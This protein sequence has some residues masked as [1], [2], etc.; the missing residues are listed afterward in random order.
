[1]PDN[2]IDI[3]NPVVVNRSIWSINDRLATYNRRFPLL[4]KMDIELSFIGR[5][6]EYQGV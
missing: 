3:D 5:I 6:A 2:E 1:M 4:D